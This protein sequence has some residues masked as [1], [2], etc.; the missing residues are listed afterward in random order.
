MENNQGN[1]GIK[2]IFFLIKCLILRKFNA[3]II[4]TQFWNTSNLTIKREQY[5]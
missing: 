5:Q 2:K 1:Q 3:Y 4:P